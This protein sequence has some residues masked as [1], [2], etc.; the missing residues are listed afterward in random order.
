MVTEIK[1]AVAIRLK[2]SFG[3]DYA[4]YS[5]KVEQGLET[6]CFF[7]K[8]LGQSR[9]QMIGNR[10]YLEVSF[11]VHYFPSV[12]GDNDE[13]D[14]VGSILFDDLEYITM[15]Y[16]DQLRGTKMSYEKFEGVL[17]FYV[18]YGM[19]GQKEREG[20]DSMAEMMEELI[21]TGGLKTDA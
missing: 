16:G 12:E 3:D 4:I 5:K 11:D 6:P 8:V 19:F 17:H 18:T 13:L 1:E 21:Y 7:I 15:V 2:Q 20:W 10:Y 14:E 9:K